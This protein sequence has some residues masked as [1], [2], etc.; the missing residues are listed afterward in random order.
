VQQPIQNRAIL[1]RVDSRLMAGGQE[2]TRRLYQRMRGTD[3]PVDIQPER[4]HAA[5]TGTDKPDRQT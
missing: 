3:G 5:N 4:W 1:A 2:R